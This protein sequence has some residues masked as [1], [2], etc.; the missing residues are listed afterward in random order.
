MRAIALAIA[1]VAAQTILFTL[2]SLLSMG[3]LKKMY[4]REVGKLHVSQRTHPRCTTEA[5]ALGRP[6]VNGRTY[7]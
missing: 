4:D 5:A 2:S 6:S 3:T 1:R 7:L